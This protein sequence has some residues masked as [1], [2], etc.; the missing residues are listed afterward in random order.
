MRSS[1]ISQAIVD[2]LADH[3]THLTA[4]EIYDAIRENFSAVNRSTIYRALKRLVDA[5]EVSIS[6]IGMGSLVYECS[7]GKPHHHLVCQSCGKIF[8]FKHE[9]V[10]NLFKGVWNANGFKV[11]TSHLILYGICNQCQDKKTTLAWS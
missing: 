6:D 10:E 7:S 8:T 9:I 5:G 3:R 2:L 11:E 1:S 4:S